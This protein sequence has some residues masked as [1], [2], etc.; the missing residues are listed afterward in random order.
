MKPK[1]CPHCGSTT[2]RQVPPDES[3]DCLDPDEA[4]GVVPESSMDWLCE[5]E[6][7]QCHNNCESFFVIKG[8]V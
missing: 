1:Y 6:E 3:C 2:L 7:W 5:V 4:L 8:D